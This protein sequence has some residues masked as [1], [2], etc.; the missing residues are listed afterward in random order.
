[1]LERLRRAPEQ[2]H[3]DGKHH[4][5]RGQREAGDGLAGQLRPHPLQ[6]AERTPGGLPGEGL[7]PDADE[8]R[9]GAL[10][11]ALLQGGAGGVGVRVLLLVGTDAVAVL[12]VDAEVLHRLVLQLGDDALAEV[13]RLGRAQ[14]HS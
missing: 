11:T 8:R 14:R 2:L 3:L 10:A 9:Q 7:E 6:R 5:R 13:R 4:L 12:E 1:V